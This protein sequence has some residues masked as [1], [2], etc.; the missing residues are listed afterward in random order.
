MKHLLY[1]SFLVVTFP[2]FGQ[3]EPFKKCSPSNWINYYYAYQGK[4]KI[5]S[6]TLVKEANEKIK[7]NRTSASGFVTVRFVINCKGEKGAY[8]VLETDKNY[9]A[10]TFDK[11][12]TDALLAYVTGLDLWPI[13]YSQYDKQNPQPRDYYAFITFKFDNG[14]IT[15]IIP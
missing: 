5:S 9:E 2:S 12:L 8:E 6:E 10:T 3:K 13:G 1:L 4:Y 14:K 15:E 11:T 7:E